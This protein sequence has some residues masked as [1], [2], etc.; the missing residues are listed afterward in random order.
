MSNLIDIIEFGAAGARR[1]NQ[2]QD[3]FKVQDLFNIQDTFNIQDLF[4]VQDLFTIQ[5]LF[6]IHS[7]F[8]INL[9]SF[10]PSSQGFVRSSAIKRLQLR[11]IMVDLE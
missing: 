9:D 8:K 2:P 6:K 11:E 7:K 4:K 10:Q 1:I 5:D 3:S